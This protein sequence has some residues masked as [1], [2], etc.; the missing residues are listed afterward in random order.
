MKPSPIR[1]I[2][3]PMRTDS[4]GYLVNECRPELIAPPW[5]DLV[6]E[7]REEVLIHLGDSVHS[8]Y[9]RGSVARGT[10][11][12]GIS[13]IDFVVVLV[14]DAASSLAWVK[15]FQ[16]A[17]RRNHPFHTGVGF[18][19]LRRTR[20]LDDERLATARFLMATQSVCLFGEDLIP[21]LPR[22]K[23]G[24]DAVVHAPALARKLAR[25]RAG[26]AVL[27]GDEEPDREKL[28]EGCRWIMKALVRT[29]FELV[30]A[31]EGTYTRDLVPCYRAFARHYP[32]KAAEMR[33]AVFLAINPIHDRG[34]LL[35]FLD[36]FGSWLA[37]EA[38]RGRAGA[39]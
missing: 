32:E 10:A 20:L 6:Q 9:L 17:A 33:R 7:A 14:D 38:R 39:P 8:V 5:D 22:Y 2:G 25:F 26:V 30:M 34:E 1:E 27:D 3:S 36:A 29:G 11:V 19:F 24:P 18:E 31:E 12:M 23:P 4:R 13:D 15:P 28:Q 21:T 37:D 35:S 16:A